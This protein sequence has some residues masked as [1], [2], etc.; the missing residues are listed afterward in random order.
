ML[1]TRIPNQYFLPLDFCVFAILNH[2]NQNFQNAFFQNEIPI[3]G[4]A[5]KFR[6]NGM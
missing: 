3:Q 6:E 1:T 2:V 5:L 4:K